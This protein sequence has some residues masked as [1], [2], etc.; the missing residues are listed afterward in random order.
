MRGD[1]RQITGLPELLLQFTGGDT[2]GTLDGFFRLLL[3]YA[4]GSNLFTFT[5]APAV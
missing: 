3:S 2:E 5:L 1:Y 4:L